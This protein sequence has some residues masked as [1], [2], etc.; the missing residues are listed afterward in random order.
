MDP[1]DPVTLL[2]RLGGVSDGATLRRGCGSEALRRAV[3]AGQVLHLGRNGYALP[4]A[5][6]AIA[7]AVRLQGVASHLS[8][9]RAWGW[10]VKHLPAAPVVTVPRNRKVEAPRRDGVDVRWAQL[11]A[12]DVV[13]HRTTRLRTV[14]DCARSLPFDE[15]LCVADSAL[16]EGRVVR[17]DLLEAASRSPRTGPGC[18]A[19]SGRARRR[20]RRQPLRVLPAGDRAGGGRPDGSRPSSRSPASATPTS[21]T[22]RCA[23]FSRPTP[24]SSTRCGRPSPT[25]S[26]ATPPWCEPDGPCCGSAG[27]T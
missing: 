18:R 6:E 23:C 13:A 21:A 1:V 11:P 19:A 15:A 10:K 16:R 25:T 22:R 26:V 12:T 14:V 5:D 17:A 3:R 27:R 4:G 7:A 8:A 20:A 9:A 24:T 2:Q